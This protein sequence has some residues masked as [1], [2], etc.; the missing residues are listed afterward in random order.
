MITGYDISL[1]KIP[2]PHQKMLIMST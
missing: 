2:K 1:G